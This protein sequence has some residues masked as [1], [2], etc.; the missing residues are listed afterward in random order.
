MRTGLFVA[1]AMVAVVC[2]ACGGGEE[3]GS[4]PGSGGGS[5]KPSVP[6]ILVSLDT[7]RADRLGMYGGQEGVSPFLD[8]LAAE[9]VVFSDCLSQSSNTASSHKSLFTG[10]L[11][12]RHDHEKGRYRLD[13]YN[14]GTL[15]QAAGYESVAY[16]GGGF[17]HPELGFGQGFEQFVIENDRGGFRPRRGFR[18]ILPQVER[19]WQGREKSRPFFLFLHSYDIHCPYWPGK[20][21]RARFAGEYQ[22]PLRLQ[23]LCGEEAFGQLFAGEQA[24]GPED[25]AYLRS[26]Y[27]GGIA[28]AD[29]LLGRFLE[30]LQEDGFLDRCLLIVTSDHGESLGEHNMVGHNF[31]WEEQL[32]VPLLIRFPGAEFGGTRC[33]EPVMLVDVLPTVLDYLDMPIPEA[34]QGES[35]LPVLQRQQSWLQDS[36][37]DTEA[38]AAE[39]TPAFD[40]LRVSKHLDLTA[41]RYDRRWKVVLRERPDRPAEVYLFDLETDPGE[42]RNVAG[43]EQGQ[44]AL[45]PILDRFQAWRESQAAGNEAARGPRLRPNI[46]SRLSGTLSELGYTDFEG[47]E[48]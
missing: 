24:P 43:T 4:G 28:M 22:G 13:R 29:E 33:S 2:S 35:L 15:L 11:V 47:E 3:E 48:E 26:M 8:A 36:E 18:G 38:S 6:V 1:L 12:E 14:I 42:S 21:W 41:F 9:S 5:P 32:Q 30:P 40:R 25:L 10:Q 31:M 17:L 34:V 19:W 45:G 44:A 7:L 23:E 20:P 37:S 46:D 39:A 16:A 27:D